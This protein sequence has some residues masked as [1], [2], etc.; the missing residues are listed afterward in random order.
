VV[1]VVL[2]AKTRVAELDLG[3][4]AALVAVEDMAR[5]RQEVLEQQIKVLLAGQQL[6]LLLPTRAVAVAVLVQSDKMVFK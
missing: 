1:T 2:K 4:P 6:G 5:I 3:R